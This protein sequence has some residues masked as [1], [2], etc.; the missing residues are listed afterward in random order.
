MYQCI[1]NMSKTQF[2]NKYN[3]QL[4]IVAYSLCSNKTRFYT[5][6]F[7]ASSATCILMSC[8]FT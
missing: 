5:K 1:S 8:Y 6:D 4:M 3:C 7:L 2:I